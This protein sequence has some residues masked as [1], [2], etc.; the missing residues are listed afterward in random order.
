MILGTP[1]VK[2]QLRLSRY[3]TDPS[4]WRLAKN[5]RLRV[6]SILMR[7]RVA[8]EIKGGPFARDTVLGKAASHLGGTPGHLE[9][10]RWGQIFI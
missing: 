6:L 7:G 1:G 8:L 10:H 2:L 9:E 4:T 5:L 3:K